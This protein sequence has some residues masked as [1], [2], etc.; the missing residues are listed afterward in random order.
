M[1]FQCI[2][3]KMRSDSSYNFGISAFDS[4]VR[5]ECNSSQ[6]YD[7]LNR[8]L[9]PPLS[10]CEV[11]AE[12]ADIHIRFLETSCGYQ[13]FFGEQEVSST[14]KLSDAAL[15]TVKA[16]DDALV[17]RL[18]TLRAVHAGAVVLEGRAVL[19]PGS[20]HAGKSSLV[21]ELLRRGAVH[22]SDE[23][24]LADEQGRVHAYPRPLLLRDGNPRQSLV[25]PADLNA[26]FATRP[27]PV[28]WIFAVDY[29]PESEWDLHEVSQGEAVMLLLQ[30]TPHEMSESPEMV[31]FFMRLVADADCYAGTRGDAVEA[32]GR[33]LEVVAGK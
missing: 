9:L 7:E 1:C 25:L 24:A 13:A 26:E 11:S 5:V 28:G 30:N 29:D 16:L 27:V 20:S 2:L 21:A 32:A 10:R 33:V 15:A 12:V 4:K 23:Y 14:A 6:I 19:I 17:H 31:E 22:L 3:M 18:R 8:V